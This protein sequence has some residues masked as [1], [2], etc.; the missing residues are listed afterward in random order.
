MFD[1]VRFL[2]TVVI[3]LMFAVGVVLCSPGWPLHPI[4]P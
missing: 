2:L 1:S 3:S 4:A